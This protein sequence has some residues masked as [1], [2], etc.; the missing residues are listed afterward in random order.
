MKTQNEQM[1]SSKK[2][3]R[4]EKLAQQKHS[5]RKGSWLAKTG[6]HLP[7]M[8]KKNKASSFTT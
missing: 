2:Y 4:T 6:H 8:L 7:I 5:L 3:N 1:A